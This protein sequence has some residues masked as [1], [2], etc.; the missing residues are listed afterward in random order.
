MCLR[1]SK[2][3]E[4]LQFLIVRS[5]ASSARTWEGAR[6]GDPGAPKNKKSTNPREGSLVVV[7][8]VVVVSR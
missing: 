2:A 8:V 4:H 1:L 3:F 7:A 6:K 5:T